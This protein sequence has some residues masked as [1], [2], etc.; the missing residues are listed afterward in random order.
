[1]LPHLTLLSS[2]GCE[3]PEKEVQVGEVDASYLLTTKDH[4]HAYMGQMR[5]R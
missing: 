1:M 5:C 4:A 3:G 2:H